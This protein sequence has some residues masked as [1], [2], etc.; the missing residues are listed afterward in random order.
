MIEIIN[1]KNKTSDETSEVLYK[2]ESKVCDMLY[3]Y[4]D[5]FSAFQARQSEKHRSNFQ[6]PF[7]L[8]L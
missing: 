3:G 6:T 7:P 1:A 5:K 2:D 4:F 8:R